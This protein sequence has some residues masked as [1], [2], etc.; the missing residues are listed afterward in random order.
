[1]PDNRQGL[2]SVRLVEVRSHRNPVS[3]DILEDKAKDRSAGVE[4]FPRMSLVPVNDEELVQQ[5]CVKGPRENHQGEARATVHKENHV[6][7]IG[8]AALQ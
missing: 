5:V 3:D 6:P 1:M 8:P 2:R 7:R 4:R